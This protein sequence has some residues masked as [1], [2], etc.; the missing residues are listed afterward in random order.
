MPILENINDPYD[1]KKLKLEELKELAEEIR[2]MIIS[3]ISKT[4]GHLA[5]NLGVVELTLALHR[6]FDSSKD[7]IVWDVGHQCY[8]HKIITGR[9]EQFRSIRQ[10]GGISGFPNIHEC[11]LDCF[12]TGHASTSISAALG[13]ASARDLKNESFKVLAV[14]GDGSLAGGMA[15]EALNHA[16]HTK[17]RFDRYL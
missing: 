3:V 13:I 10:Y 8:A 17:N 15:F 9:R 12:G 2:Q 4:G 16:G 14:I 6:C 7:K 1:L 11:E 5:S